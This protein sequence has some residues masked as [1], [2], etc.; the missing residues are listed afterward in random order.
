M[1]QELNVGI[2]ANNGEVVLYTA[3][4]EESMIGNLVHLKQFVHYASYSNHQNISFR[5]AFKQMQ[6]NT[7]IDQDS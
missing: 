4:K 1:E 6:T 2:T 7:I 5:K 3:F